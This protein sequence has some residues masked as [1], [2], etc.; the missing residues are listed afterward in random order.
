MLRI[1]KKLNFALEEQVGPPELFVGRQKEFSWFLGGWYDNL[2]RGKPKSQAI[3]A[4][5]KK[6]KT[7][8]LQ[9]L[10]NVHWTAH[11]PEVIPFYFTIPEIRTTQ[12]EFAKLFLRALINQLVAFEMNEPQLVTKPVAFEEIPAITQDPVYLE[13]HRALLSYEKISNWN[14]MWDSASRAPSEIASLRDL[15]IIQIIDEFQYINEYVVDQGGKVIDTMSGTYLT[16]AEQRKAPLIV[17]GSEVH[18][19]LRIVNGL[20]GRFDS[21]SMENWPEDEAKQAVIQYAKHYQTRVDKE[22]I[23]HIW[24]LTQGDPL[25]ISQLFSS[26][27]NEKKN[28]TD[29][30]VITEVYEKEMKQGGGI[31]GTWM[32]YMA[33]IF[34]DVNESNA[35][36]IILYLFQQA[37]ECTRA[38]IIQDLKLK[39]SEQQVQEKLQALIKADLISQGSGFYRYTISR[40]KTYEWVFRGAFQEEIDHFVPDIRSEALSQMGIRNYEIGLFGEFKLRRKL[41]K[42][43][44]LNEIAKNGPQ[45]WVDPHPIQERVPKK[46]ENQTFEIDLIVESDPEIWIEVKTLKKKFGKTQLRRILQLHQA[47][48][49][50]AKAPILF[51]YAPGGFTKEASEELQ[52]HGILYGM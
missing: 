17:S 45:I 29:P 2:I 5:R 28:F 25:Y 42:G 47:L 12:A 16:L 38:E 44:Y 10:F 36:R 7:V 8:F 6:G 50:T 26:R 27:H 22:A 39:E 35:K 51:V 34:K 40:D 33:K 20:V 32:E 13:Y 21:W 41:Q 11:N 31:Y 43:F 3:V 49:N 24:K 23:E 52:K 15:R 18:W 30:L 14:M 48:S 1:P 9:R 37:R 19:L 4:R 46:I